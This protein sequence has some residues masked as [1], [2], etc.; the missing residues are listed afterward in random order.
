MRCMKCGKEIEETRAFCEN[1]L[2]V[3]S[4]RP[5]KSD[6]PVQLPVRT[7]APVKKA[8][9][10]KRQRTPEEQLQQLRG[11]V[12]WMSLALTCIVLALALTVSYLV[13]TTTEQN[14]GQE[15]GR[16]YNTV[17]TVNETD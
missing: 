3:M 4:Q 15:I 1:C 11:A 8:A 7:H 2:A 12:K 10:R 6:T 16:N 5:V 17:G 14:A 9:P 13:H